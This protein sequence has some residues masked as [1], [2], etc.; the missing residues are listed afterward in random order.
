MCLRLLG[1]Y[2]GLMGGYKHDQRL[3]ELIDQFVEV[4]NKVEASQRID[5]EA[6]FLEKIQDPEVRAQLKRGV[7][8]DFFRWLEW[9]PHKAPDRKSRIKVSQSVV[10]LHPNSVSVVFQ[11]QRVMGGDIQIHMG[12]LNRLGAEHPRTGLVFYGGSLL[13]QTLLESKT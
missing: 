1:D 11:F 8:K 9:I 12:L 2:H 7:D 4:L 3:D 5:R 13:T 10:N 6:A